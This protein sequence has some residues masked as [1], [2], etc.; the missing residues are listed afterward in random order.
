M[1]PDNYSFHTPLQ[2]RAATPAGSA[3]EGLVLLFTPRL[4]TASE[5]QA[6]LAL[7]APPAAPLEATQVQQ[8]VSAYLA[9]A[10]LQRCRECCARLAWVPASSL[11][12]APGAAEGPSAAAGARQEAPS[13]SGGAGAGRRLTRS[14]SGGAPATACLSQREEYGEALA[15]KEQVLAGLRAAITQDGTRGAVCELP[16]LAADE[17]SWGAFSSCLGLGPQEQ[18]EV[19]TGAAATAA[20][21]AAGTAPAGAVPKQQQEREQEGP[22]LNDGVW[23][24]GEG[25]LEEV[26]GTLKVLLAHLEAGC[27][28]GRDTQDEIRKAVRQRYRQ[29]QK[30]AAAAAKAGPRTGAGMAGPGRRGGGP[31]GMPRGKGQAAVQQAKLLQEREKVGGGALT[32][33]QEVS[34]I[35]AWLGAAKSQQ[36]TSYRVFLIKRGSAV[37]LSQYFQTGP[38]T[39][40]G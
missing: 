19:G 18:P 7:E 10:I 3:A 13:G 16:V 15:S 21:A 39:C 20:V 25:S 24:S 38:C 32:A 22:E 17:L 14:S 26:V 31:A 9:P 34:W 2:M 29:Q 37:V 5:L 12:A 30:A 4:A 33:K 11:G 1:S 36:C 6:F 23:P 35:A 40:H 27:R 8:L 28:Q